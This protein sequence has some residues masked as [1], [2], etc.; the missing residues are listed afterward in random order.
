M[1]SLRELQQAFAAALTPEPAPALDRALLTVVT[2]GGGLDAAARVGIYAEM[3]RARL[4][5]VL[6]EDYP[7]VL[8]CVGDEA[9][10]ALVCRYLVRHPSTHP[11]V[12]HAGGRFP[13]F[14]ASERAAAPFLADLAR[15]EWARVEV[16]DAADAEP[17]R[18]SDVQALPP[19]AWSA[20]RLQTIPACLLIDCAWPAHAAWETGKAPAAPAATAIRVWREEWSV[21]HA[22]V[23]ARERWALAML[24]RG[25]TF[26]ALCAALADGQDDE[27][28]TREA[29][30]LLLRWLE[31]GVL[32]RRPLP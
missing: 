21:S 10:D 28:A 29:G 3:Y 7:R 11:S 27:A 13:D 26:G 17:L 12:R 6:R 32:A 19:A 15:L 9:F 22:A 31:D 30:G 20:L 25:E 5:D 8:A 16:F 24:Q 4:V 23:G 2:G 1:P 18:L 14:L